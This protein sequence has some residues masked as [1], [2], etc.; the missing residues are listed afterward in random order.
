MRGTF[1]TMLIV[2]EVVV[3]WE[4]H[5]VDR[6]SIVN[7]LGDLLREWYGFNEE[8]E[9]GIFRE[10]P[11]EIGSGEA[12]TLGVILDVGKASLCERACVLVRR[13]YTACRVCQCTTAI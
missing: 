12:T 6:R 9:P 4:T 2:V 1:D 8:I 5:I 7:E 11:I 13:A 3:S 10:I